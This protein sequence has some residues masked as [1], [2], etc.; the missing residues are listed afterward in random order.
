MG[1]LGNPVVSHGRCFLIGTPFNGLQ[2]RRQQ[3]VSR[4]FSPIAVAVDAAYRDRRW[5]TAASTKA[6][7]TPGEYHQHYYGACFRDTEGSKLCASPARRRV[8]IASGMCAVIAI[9]G[10]EARATLAASGSRNNICCQQE[11]FHEQAESSSRRSS[12]RIDGRRIS[13][14]RDVEVLHWW[15]SGGEAKSVAELKKMLE[16]GPEVEGFCGGWWRRRCTAMDSAQ[17]RVVSGNP[18]TA[19]RSGPSDSGNNDAEGSLVTSVTRR[20]NGQVAE[21]CRRRDEVQVGVC[22]Q[23]R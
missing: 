2:H 4:P 17:R 6:R 10:L 5:R 3:L 13:R 12:T 1:G 7:W 14:R 19:A 18:P 16:P 9:D 23:C 15:T 22:C 20:R 11:R 8:N 21:S